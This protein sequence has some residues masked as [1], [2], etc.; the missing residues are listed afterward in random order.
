MK[1][2]ESLISGMENIGSLIG[3]TNLDLKQVEKNLNIDP[4]SE[5]RVQEIADATTPTQPPQA[6]QAE[7]GGA[8]AGGRIKNW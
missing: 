1:M 3:S 6:K 8:K 5:V 4:T 7:A 2:D